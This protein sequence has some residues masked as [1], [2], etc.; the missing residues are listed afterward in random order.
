MSKLLRAHFARLWK[1]KPFF[2]MCAL[3]FLMGVFLPIK[4]YWDNVRLV[5]EWALDDGAFVY[6]MFLLILSAVFTPLF[7]GTEHSDGTMRNQLV[8]GHRRGTVYLSN[9]VVCVAG[10]VFMSLC[11]LVP[12]LCVGIILVGTFECGAKVAILFALTIFALMVAVT[13]SSCIG[14]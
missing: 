11:Y 7:V 14:Y 4:H 1:E 2:I 13:E 3:M 5:S 9:L 8:V 12:Y 6:A 10:V